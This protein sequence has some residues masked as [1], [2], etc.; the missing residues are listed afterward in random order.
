MNYIS[1]IAKILEEPKQTK[2]NDE[3]Y[4]NKFIVEFPKVDGTN[5]E[6]IVQVAIWNLDSANSSQYLFIGN[7]II[8]EGY[9]STSESIFNEKNSFNKK[10]I[11]ISVTK[12]SPFLLY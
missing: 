5:F 8:L 1:F 2:F 12:V 9:I 11:E 10:H 3:I 7:Y 4:V 6:P